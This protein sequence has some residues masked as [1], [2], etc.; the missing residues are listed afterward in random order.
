MEAYGNLVEGDDE[1]AWV[2]TGQEQQEACKSLQK[3]LSKKVW[4]WTH[5]FFVSEVHVSISII[6]FRHFWKISKKQTDHF[7]AWPN[8]YGFQKRHQTPSVFLGGNFQEVPKQVLLA[9]MTR[10]RGAQRMGIMVSIDGDFMTDL[11]KVQRLQ[12]MKEWWP[13]ILCS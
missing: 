11:P 2:D 10:V 6:F 12:A 7:V 5:F 8:S 4:E 1:L 13:M 3:I 9:K